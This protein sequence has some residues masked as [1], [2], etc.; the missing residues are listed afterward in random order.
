MASLVAALA[1]CGGGADDDDTPTSPATGGDTRTPAKVRVSGV[2]AVGTPI[3]GQ[4]VQITC[5]DGTRV[6]VGT[7]T[8]GFFSG[9]VEA[10]GFPCLLSVIPI[11][12]STVAPPL[13]LWS[14]AL[15]P[16]TS[17]ITPITDLILHA[18]PDILLSDLSNNPMSIPNNFTEGNLDIGYS[19]IAPFLKTLPG[20][21]VILAGFDPITSPFQALEGDPGDDLLETYK[22]ALTAANLTQDDANAKVAAKLAATQKTYPAT[23]FT[24]PNLTTFKAG[25]SLNLDGSFGVAVPDPVRGNFSAK[26]KVDTSGNIIGLTDAGPFTGVIS[27]LGNR[28]GELCTA[29]GVG[30]FSTATPSQYAY[31]SSDLTEVTDPTELRGKYFTEYEDC[32]VSGT[33]SIDTASG[34]YTFIGTQ[35]GASPNNPVADFEKSFSVQGRADVLNDATVRGKAYKYTDGSGAVT[36]VYILVST[37]NGVTTP[38]LDQTAN[39]VVL[40]YSIT[41]P[42]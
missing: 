42:R 13:P 18:V 19:L 5:S 14:V 25:A 9:D 2:A 30:R 20:E 27:Q 17:N 4:P 16:G 12:Y 21:P 15:A 37:K 26:A 38:M 24:T 40:G 22:M 8:S 34:S 35:Q 32:V 29:N 36:Y 11:T 39:Y 33:A 28:A 31:V 1:A 3:V 10:N 23:A 7:D 6:A 41:P